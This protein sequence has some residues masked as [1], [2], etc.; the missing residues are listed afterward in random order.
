MIKN[1]KLILTCV[2][3]RLIYDIIKALKDANDYSLTL[4]GIDQN[5]QAHGRLLCDKFYKVPNVEIEP[6]KWLKKILEICE[7][8]KAKIIIPLSDGE[9]KVIAKNYKLFSSKKILTS[10][11]D[12]RFINL[13]SNKFD[14]MSFLKKKNINVGSFVEIDS[15]DDIKYYANNFGYPQKKLVLKPKFGRGSRGVIICDSNKKKFE[16]LLT[17]RF[18]GVGDIDSIKKKLIQLKL[19][20]KDYI[21]MPYYGNKIFDVDCIAKRGKLIEVAVRERQLKNPLM[22]T[23]TGHKIKMDKRIE[24]YVKKLC[25]VFKVDGPADFDIVKDDKG[26]PILLDSGCRFSGSV[27]GSYNAGK[28]MLSQLLRFLLG[29]PFKEFKI[30]DGCVLRPYISMIEVPKKN[31]KDFL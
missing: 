19:S 28:N 31:E 3:G 29:I 20:V 10:A 24:N 15:L 2:G 1:H 17:D 26:K 6:K 25:G 12:I 18:C 22:P 14:M 9:A 8:E 5:K 11:K 16:D 4:I 21:M 13:I 30:R 27:G 7:K 23:S